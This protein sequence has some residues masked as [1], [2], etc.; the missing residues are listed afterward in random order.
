[1]FAPVYDDDGEIVLIQALQAHQGDTGGKD[2]GG[3]SVDV[4]ELQAE[5]LIIPVV[6]LVAAAASP[7]EDVI[8]ML[9]R[10]N[11]LPSFAGDIAAMISAVQKGAER[12]GELIGKYGADV[13]ARGDQLEHRRDRAALPRRGRAAGPTGATRRPC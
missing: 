11:R 4:R 3:F 10:N 9:V 13:R 6:K 8:A 2:P 5:G 7:R 1:M 12:L